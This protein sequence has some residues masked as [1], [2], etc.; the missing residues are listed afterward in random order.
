M[1]LV[2]TRPSGDGTFQK[3]AAVV[4]LS[5]EE[6]N[7]TCHVQHEGLPEPRTLRWESPAQPPFPILGVVAAAILLVAV[8]AGAG[9]ALLMWRRKR[10]GV[11]GGGYAQA[12][13][14]DSAQGSDSS[15]EA[16]KA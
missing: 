4:V 10:A 2:E 3:W 13:N 9:A 16:C 5:G 14:N 8:L 1:E 6:H 7:Y 11:K 15:L 12:A